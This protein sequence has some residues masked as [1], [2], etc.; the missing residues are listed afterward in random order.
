MAR[1]KEKINPKEIG[2]RLD[3][4]AAF[5][6]SALVKIAPAWP[7]GDRIPPFNADKFIGTAL[8]SL[9]RQP[10]LL[11]KNADLW[12]LVGALRECVEYGLYPD[13]LRGY[14]YLTPRWDKDLNAWRCV[15]ILG[16]RGFV[17]LFRRSP[18]AA[19][20]NAVQSERVYEGDVFEVEKGL[21]DKLVWR[22]DLKAAETPD[23]KLRLVYSILR[24]KDGTADFDYTM[25]WQIDQIRDFH[26]D[27]ASSSFSPW[28]S[29]SDLV[30]SWMEKK[31][32][33]KQVLKLS[34]A[35]DDVMAAAVSVD[36]LGD[37][38][39]DQ[40]LGDRLDKKMRDTISTLFADGKPQV[41]VNVAAEPGKV[42]RKPEGAIAGR[43][44]GALMERDKPPKPEDKPDAAKA[45]E[46]KATAPEG[47][48]DAD[49][50][51]NPPASEPG[52]DGTPEE[53]EKAKKKR[54][55]PKGSKNKAKTGPSVSPEPAPEVKPDE[56]TSEV[57]EPG[58]DPADYERC[59]KCEHMVSKG[60]YDQHVAHCDG[61]RE[62]TELEQHIA[63]GGSA[64]AEP[65]GTH[66]AGEEHVY[67]IAG[68]MDGPMDPDKAWD[69][70]ADATK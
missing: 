68:P 41:N 46:K 32:S 20:G 50:Q 1:E 38:S 31:T 39:I 19:E 28:N 56:T 4:L 15:A 52:T 51:P 22:P 57:A 42:E 64:P 61:K 55:R 60:V 12:S 6:P 21:V 25:R 47:G 58:G 2:E 63:A 45:P 44:L 53:V 59:T 48:V 34:P 26:S 37:V 30:R 36:D 66:P 11:Q 9:Q 43:T 23:R 40:G 67:P 62:S 33:L 49:G 69:D 8:Q 54:G 35:L 65:V 27:A 24:Y 5:L 7:Q 70:L 29:K 10:R 14:F 16:Y 13:D 17:Y 3:K 18:M